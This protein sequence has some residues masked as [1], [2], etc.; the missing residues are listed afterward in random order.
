MT[1]LRQIVDAHP[2]QAGVVV[3]HR[4]ICKLVLL[5]AMS[6]GE[7]GFWKIQQDLAC[8]NLLE[9]DGQDWTVRFMNLTGHLQGANAN[10]KIDF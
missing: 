7:A 9:W 10:L 1:A 3:S 2:D 5:E 6:V 8:M 4:V